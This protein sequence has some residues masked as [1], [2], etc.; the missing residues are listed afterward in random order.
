MLLS[1]GMDRAFTYCDQSLYKEAARPLGE[2]LFHSSVDTDNIKGRHFDYTLVLDA[3]TCVVRDSVFE[4]LE[5][6]AGNPERAIIQPA[7]KMDCKPGD[8]IFIHIEAMRQ[9]IAAPLTNALTAIMGQSGFYGKGLLKNVKYIER[10]L[11]TPESP[12]E[13]VPIDVLSHDTFEAAVVGP[14]YAGDVHLLEAPCGNY[15]TWDIRE[16]RWNRGELLLA[17]YF[18]PR[19]HRGADALDAEQ[20]SRQDFQQARS[21]NQG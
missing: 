18:F 9:A 4:M 19:V 21:P 11:G 15:V 6:G 8:S 16:R 13:V 7:I 2:P 17:M 5:I 12:V 3:D 20:T 1:E 14:L 10:C